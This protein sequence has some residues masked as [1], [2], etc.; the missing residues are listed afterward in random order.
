M[1]KIWRRL[2]PVLFVCAL[3]FSAVGSASA[4][5]GGKAAQSTSDTEQEMTEEEKAQAQLDA[6]YAIPVESNAWEGW[7]EGPGT[8]GEAA[9]VM[10]V[11]TGAVLYAKNIDAAMYPASITKVL[12]ALLALE[13]G[14]LSD[15]VTFSHDCVSF[16]QYGDSSVGLKEGDVITLEQ[17][18]YA[19]LLASANEAAYA[20]GENVGKNA[21]HD[22]DWFIEQMNAKVKELGGVNSHF[23]NT[24]GLPD[25][26]HYTCAR[27]MALIGRALFKYPEV[28][29]IMQTMQYTIPASD[30][31]EEHV[32]Q[33]KDKMLRAENAN[34]Y[35]Y[36]IGGKTG[37]TNAAKSTLITMADNGKMQLVAVV[38]HTYGKNVYPDTKKMLKYAFKNFEKLPIAGNE[39]SADVAEILPMEAEETVDADGSDESA[40]SYV[41]VPKGTAFSD[42]QMTLE[43]SEDGASGEAV[44]SYTYGGQMVGRARAR[45]SDA[46]LEANRLEAGTPEPSEEGSGQDEE[47]SEGKSEGEDGIFARLKEWLT[48]AKGWLTGRAAQ[49]KDWL[50]GRLAR[51]NAKEKLL[52]VGLCVLLAILVLAYIRIRVVR[53]RKRRRRRARGAKSALDKSA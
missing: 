35:K 39:T 23:V 30:T 42:L 3:A 19:T 37:Y 12:T 20:V 24:N 29:K 2:T 47:K 33:Q 14:N 13:Y 38:L 6:A 4:T 11:G 15:T 45:L 44:L 17:A 46:Y 9:I 49:A 43:P 41:V 8:Y 5:E 21:G 1:G 51:K 31:V 18:L 36:A 25:E 53:W 10:E 34:Y 28:F 40:E 22:Y 7:P 16:L 48:R 52:M 50:A 27:D 26:N 32:F